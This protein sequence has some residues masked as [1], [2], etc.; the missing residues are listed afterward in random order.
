MTFDPSFEVSVNAQET[1]REIGNNVLW[2]L[3]SNNTLKFQAK[4]LPFHSYG[5]GVSSIQPKEQNYFS[6]FKS[7]F[8]SFY[9][10]T[11]IKKIIFRQIKHFSNATFFI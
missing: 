8:F 3:L 6:I 1:G 5:N 9:N 2:Q 4:G 7:Q 11:Y 10:R